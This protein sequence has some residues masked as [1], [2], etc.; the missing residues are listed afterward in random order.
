MIAEAGQY[1]AGEKIESSLASSP[2]FSGDRSSE[3]YREWCREFG[4]D[5]RG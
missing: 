3:D 4:I 1:E 5:S 2:Q